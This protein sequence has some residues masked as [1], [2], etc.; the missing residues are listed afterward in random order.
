MSPIRKRE[1]LSTRTNHVLFAM[2]LRFSGYYTKAMLMAY[3]LTSSLLALGDMVNLANGENLL[4]E[5]ARFTVPPVKW[6]TLCILSNTLQTIM[7]P[8]DIQFHIAMQVKNKRNRV[9]K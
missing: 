3:T 7:A 4:L 1:D 5:C 9:K 6:R 2:L 8:L